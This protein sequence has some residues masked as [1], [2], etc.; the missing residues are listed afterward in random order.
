MSLEWKQ[1]KGHLPNEHTT[2]A[3]V[4][5]SPRGSGPLPLPRRALPLRPVFATAVG[6]FPRVHYR[7]GR[8]NLVRFKLGD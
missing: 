8:V 2:T 3:G 4:A 6:I 7:K 1:V 5:S